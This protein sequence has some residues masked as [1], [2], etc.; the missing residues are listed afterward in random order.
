[1]GTPAVCG[2]RGQ[3][4]L[5][6]KKGADHSAP[7]LNSISRQPSERA[8]HV[9]KHRTTQ[10]VVGAVVEVIADGRTAVATT[11]AIAADNRH[12]SSAGL[13]VGTSCAEAGSAASVPSSEDKIS[14][15]FIKVSGE[16]AQQAFAVAKVRWPTDHA[17]CSCRHTTAGNSIRREQDEPRRARP[18]VTNRPYNR[19]A[20]PKVWQFG[21]SPSWI[22][23]C[24]THLCD[25]LLAS[26]LTA[27]SYRHTSRTNP[28]RV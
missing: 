6:K 12:S 11:R 1:M 3:C 9:E 26:A 17:R 28:A 23:R 7:F 20:R 21:D 19:P 22:V 4:A 24:R 5:R 15:R 10:E 13:A 25:A 2:P 27:C 16:S 18:V 8:G 14:I